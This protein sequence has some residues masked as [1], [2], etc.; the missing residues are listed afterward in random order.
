MTTNAPP[1][2]IVALTL[3]YRD[4]VRTQRCVDSLLAAGAKG[5]LVWDNSADA[6]LSAQ[7]L[8]QS[9]AAQPAVQIVVSERNL[10]FAAGVNRGMEVIAQRWPGA[11]VFLINNDAVIDPSALDKLAQAL[12]TN[13]QAV[14]AYPR[15]KHGER[16]LGTMH[17][18]R[19]FAL[20]SFDEP[21]PG[22]F[23][24]PSGAALLV[25]TD[26]TQAPLLDEDFFMYGEDVMLGWRL[27]TQRMAHV[28]EILV[29]HEASASARNGSLFYEMHVAA[30]HWLLG[31]KL[32]R[33]PL[34]QLLLFGGRCLSLPA[35]ALLRTMR[36]RSLN[37]LIGL[38]RGWLLAWQR[39]RRE[40]HS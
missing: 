28:A 7:A 5:V 29:E 23:P 19:L 37:P 4:A 9:L 31:H 14:I 25:A 27:G 38:V 16:V 8:R 40:R 15:I 3:N 17:Y 2:P 6:G 32:A 18:Q 36:Q 26:R 11:W 12:C 30:G 13:P 10:G 24:Y 34:D 39:R 21:M 33:N 35:R 22:S 20:L 1:P